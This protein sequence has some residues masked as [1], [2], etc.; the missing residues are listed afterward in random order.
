MCLRF[1]KRKGALLSFTARAL[2]VFFV[3]TLSV[4]ARADSKLNGIARYD[5]FDSTQFVAALYLPETTA[6]ARALLEGNK[7]VLMATR[8]VTDS[9]SSRRFLGFWLENLSVNTSKEEMQRN[10]QYVASF[11]Q[12]FQE[13]L[14]RG[15]LVEFHYTPATKLDIKVNGVRIGNIPSLEFSR[16]LL[17][18]WIGD[19]PVSSVF[20]AKLLAAG[21][22]SEND[23]QL[24]ERYHPDE[25]RV[26]EV[27]AWS[28][29]KPEKE[30]K[31]EPA[32]TQRA[33]AKTAATV[34]KP[35][36]PRTDARVPIAAVKA[37]SERP[38]AASP[39]PQ[40]K[41]QANAV[42]TEKNA[43]IDIAKLEPSPQ[44]SATP[45][46]EESD[47]NLALTEAELIAQ[48]DYYRTA[49]SEIL[50]YKT[51]PRQAFQLKLE[52]DVRV[53]I[54]VDRKGNVLSTRIVERSEHSLF[55]KQALEAVRR[56]NPLPPLPPQIKGNLFTFTMPMQY[57]LPI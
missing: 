42:A 52:G 15:D 12:M 38:T 47:F 55:E 57:K 26:R 9:L 35:V 6:D 49:R 28:Q 56:A 45:P 39:A 53:E 34:A 32:I 51:L 10:I 44:P 33:L 13:T 43:E 14:V 18:A 46:E 50:K 41:T 24:F 19:I 27:I 7:S 22:Y 4:S 30:I 2:I 31:T 5:A 40:I 48:E 36:S 29:P 25:N 11:N 3:S 54:A 1:V 16:L 23:L 37:P 8:V 20:R 21:K 17:S